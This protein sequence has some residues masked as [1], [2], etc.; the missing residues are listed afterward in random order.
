VDKFESEFAWS[1]LTVLRERASGCTSTG[2]S[3]VEDAVAAF[4]AGGLVVVTDDETRENEGDLIAA[5]ELMTPE[6]M[7]FLVRHTGGVVCVAVDGARLDALRLPQMVGRNED[8]KA[9]AFTVSVDLRHGITTGISAA[10]RAATVRALADP[11]RGA[12]DFVRPGHVF[13]LRARP[14]GVLERPGHTEAAVDLARLAGLQTAGVISEIVSADGSMARQEDL[15]R[16]ASRYQL[17]LTSV[18]DLV[19]YRRRTEAPVRRTAATGLP[20]A[21]GTFRA[22]CYSSVAGT[23]PEA[24]G[25]EHLALVLG[26]VDGAE[27]VLVRVHSECLTGDVFGSRR[28]DC[29]EQLNAGLARIAQ[30]GSGVLVYLRGH[31]GRG[32]GLANKLR[33]YSLQDDG[34]D[35]LDANLA[36]GLP[37]DARE[38][39]V[40]AHVLRDLG[41]RSARVLT[42]NGAKCRG[43]MENGLPVSGREPLLIQ[44]GLE[45]IGYLRA[46]RDRMGHDL[47][48]FDE[49]LRAM[50]LEAT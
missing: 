16:F 17:P 21:H 50:L 40:A 39:H 44:P 20:T 37:A 24:T 4:R 46:K 33:A 8:P 45:N 12:D 15:R 7:A 26:D 43:L 28:C 31:E 49:K 22:Y 9:T 27:D 35:T 30:A 42:N 29:G 1:S 5:A 10:D 47:G 18:D 3:R 32:I 14:G 23:R 6:L 11:A 38:Y 34:L 48:D 13:P 41:V 2:Q 36:L 19:R 25:Q